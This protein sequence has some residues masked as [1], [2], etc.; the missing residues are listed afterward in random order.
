MDKNARMIL[1]PTSV[2]G[3]SGLEATIRLIVPKFAQEKEI[4]IGTI[5]GGKRHITVHRKEQEPLELRENIEK[6]ELTGPYASVCRLGPR[7]ER[8]FHEVTR[9]QLMFY[10]WGVSE[11]VETR[12]FSGMPIHN[13]FPSP[14]ESNA[15]HNKT[16]ISG[17]RYTKLP[18]LS[19]D[20]LVEIDSYYEISPLGENEYDR[21]FRDVDTS[22]G[23]KWI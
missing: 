18:N 20:S 15:Y 13:G 2:E 16:H 21:I 1:E 6:E 12:Y 23:L 17:S 8:A 11:G 7:Y 5:T 22:F 19:E 10:L 14:K 3:T 9:D 4:F